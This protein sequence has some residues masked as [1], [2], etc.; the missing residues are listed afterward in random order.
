MTFYNP[1]ISSNGP[2][3]TAQFLKLQA[4]LKDI[5]FWVSRNVPQLNSEQTELI[6]LRGNYCA[7]H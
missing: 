6:T 1:I 3:Q 2:D 4:C 5:R 7:I